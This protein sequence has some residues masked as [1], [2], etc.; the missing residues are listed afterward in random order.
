MRE[1]YSTQQ[2]ADIIN[3]RHLWFK[4]T[5]VKKMKTVAL[6]LYFLSLSSRMLWGLWLRI[7]FA[8]P[9]VLTDIPDFIAFAT[10]RIVFKKMKAFLGAINVFFFIEL[11]K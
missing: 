10:A 9:L 1:Q 8:I 4:T 11:C 6:P 2:N 5:T 7:S 3:N